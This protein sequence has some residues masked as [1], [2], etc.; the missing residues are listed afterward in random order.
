MI[1]DNGLRNMLSFRHS[2]NSG[3]LLENTV[4]IEL[5]RRGNNVFFFKRHNECDF[6]VEEAGKISSLIQ[7]FY[8]MS[9]QNE[10]RE[11]SGLTEAAKIF[12]LQAGTIITYDEGKSIIKEGI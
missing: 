3:R 1:L 12:N 5:M 11:I 2:P 9:P 10:E 4:F 6:I 7:V 8:S